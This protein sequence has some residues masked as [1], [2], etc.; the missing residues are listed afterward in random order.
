MNTYAKIL[1]CNIV[2]PKSFSKDAVSLVGG[3]LNPKSTKRLGVVKGGAK[4]IKEHPWF[5]NFD[6]DGLRKRL[7]K[8]PIIPKIKNDLDLSNFEKYPED[9]SVFADYVEDGNNYFKDF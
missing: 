9:N 6:W 5:I 8:A 7:I 1:Q 4:L 2:Y 3:L